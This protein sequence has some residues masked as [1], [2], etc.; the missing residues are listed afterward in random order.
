MNISRELL[1]KW[2]RDLRIPNGE[3][4]VKLAEYY[5]TTTDYILGYSDIPQSVDRLQIT[6][7]TLGLS[8]VATQNLIEISNLRGGRASELMSAIL[9]S[10]QL[11]EL[12]A[13]FV[14]SQDG[15]NRQYHNLRPR[16]NPDTP[17]A[18]RPMPLS[19]VETCLD[20]AEMYILR[21]V[22]KIDPRLREMLGYNELVEVMQNGEH[23]EN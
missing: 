14:A 7:A 1:D 13:E 19:F 4:I 6:C 12:F 23:Q 10:P 20:M 21:A 8:L 2:E 5:G 18:L 3:A 15:I 11:P 16:D 17:T 22:K 9:E